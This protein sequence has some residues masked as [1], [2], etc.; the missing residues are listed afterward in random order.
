MAWSLSAAHAQTPAPAPTATQAANQA[1]ASVEASQATPIRN[2]VRR[3]AAKLYLAGSKLYEAEKFEE[4]MADYEK[5]AELDPDNADYP[6]AVG[7][8]RSHAVTALIQ[9]AAKDRNRGD[10]VA[11]RAALAHALELDPNNAEV[12]L[13][14]NG[15]GDAALKGQRRPVYEQGAKT[16]GEDEELMPVPG[17]H[18]F[19]LRTDE[20]QIVKLVFQSYGI[21]TTVDESV[22]TTQSR[23]D[24][25]NI[26]Y[27]DA[28]RI[29]EMVTGTFHV[30]LDAHRV[31]VARDTKENRA[32]FERL[33]LE[34]V[35]L[36]GLTQT[37]L[38]DVA[39]LAKNVFD[40]S[41][42][43]TNSTSGTI[44]LRAS[45]ETLTAFNN[46]IR[47]LLEGK[48]QVLLEVRM[49]QLGHTNARKTGLNPPQSMSVFNVAAEAQ[50]IFT[51]NQALIQQIINSGLAA[52]GD[53]WTIL[54][55]LAASGQVPNSLFSSGIAT[56]GGTLTNCGTTTY[57]CT[58]AATTFAVAPGTFSANLSLNSSDTRELDDLQL[59]LGDGETATLKSGT[60][61]P[62]Q[63]SSFSSIGSSS[64]SS[65]A[66]LSGAGNSSSLQS[67][68]ASYS[69]SVPNIP[70]VEYQDL[71]LTL[72]AMPKVMRGQD[73]ALTIDLKI[74]ALA[75]SSVNGNPILNN[76][77]WSGV[78]TVKQDEAVVVIS[79]LDKSES[80]AV[81]GVPGISEVPGLNDLT[82]NDKNKNY[83]SLL[84][85][86]TPH[87]VRGTQ[88]AGHSPM[89]RIERGSSGRQ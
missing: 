43:A 48:N 82:G 78:V 3:R 52:P 51:Q 72:K 89:M 15:M 8:A 44:A 34:T 59:R 61:Y 32:R 65:L 5:A 13:H 37:E 54:G 56:F 18:S 85:V 29:V 9:A 22:R 86:I 70:Q 6:L 42:A 4:A 74:S 11:E 71:G 39:N 26:G 12:S 27:A 87:V 1:A 24:L 83:A 21:E 40:I 80:R 58:G 81:S 76:R 47:I 38:S 33:E 67:L 28:I 63:T 73:V 57:S 17:I 49:I 45:E 30:P 19:H 53:F 60:K 69:N 77:S 66:G 7:V 84:I 36:S 35:Y 88:A 50:S 55:I 75:G 23:L 79:E 20:R 64:L 2:S 31:L 25:D 10:N 62:I 16:V 14:L 68:L 46:T 41:Q